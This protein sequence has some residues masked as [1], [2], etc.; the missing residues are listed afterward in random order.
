MTDMTETRV[1]E[2]IE[3]YGPEPVAWPDAERDAASDLLRANSDVFADAIAEAR[4]LD[5]ALAGLEEPQPPADLAARIIA[6]APISREQE[7]S[8]PGLIAWIK[9]QLMVGGSILPSASALASSAVGLIIGYGA[10]GTTQV[11]DVDYADEA[12]YAA[13]DEGYDFDVGDF[14]G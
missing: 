2:L 1:F 6:S 4:A 13:F 12:V 14:G 11:A 5:L 10:I 9:S 3:A 7:T 8:A